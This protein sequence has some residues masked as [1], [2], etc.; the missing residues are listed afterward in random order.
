M[1]T[2]IPLQIVSLLEYSIYLAACLLNFMA[3]LWMAS[4]T[5]HMR[6]SDFW[7]ARTSITVIGLIYAIITLSLFAPPQY[8]PPESV[9]DPGFASLI[10]KSIF[11]SEAGTVHV[12]WVWVTPILG[13]MMMLKFAG[14][15][16]PNGIMRIATYITAFI[17]AWGSYIV[18]M[19]QNAFGELA[20]YFGFFAAN[21]AAAT[22]MIGNSLQALQSAGK[23]SIKR[24][25]YIGV[26][27]VYFGL[28]VAAAGT[29][30]MIL[31]S[32]Y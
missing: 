23:A 29:M 2:F 22:W 25:G 18:F 32:P 7:L 20:T 19:E 9:T 6:E 4:A 15:A 1:E 10:F 16:I 27:F 17:A 31:E 3:A 24:V 8:P 30:Q 21:L 26:S 5:S 11:A 14:I 13:M 28:V 12:F